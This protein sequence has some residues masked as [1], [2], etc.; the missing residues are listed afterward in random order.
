[1]ATDEDKVFKAL[2]DASRRDLLDRL[3]KKGGLTLGALCEEHDMSRQA[4]AKHLALLEEALPDGY[5]GMTVAQISAAAGYKTVVREVDEASLKK[6]LE[7]IQKFL[8]DGVAKGKVTEDARAQ[9]LGGA[10]ALARS[11]LGPDKPRTSA[12]ASAPS[13]ANS[14]SSR[15]T[16]LRPSVRKWRRRRSPIGR[17]PVA[18]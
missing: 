13:G 17:A 12:D 1:M 8:D 2:A 5:A 6:G 18:R 11:T 3:R 10:Y 15:S 9:T 14:S 7:R 16:T 4:V